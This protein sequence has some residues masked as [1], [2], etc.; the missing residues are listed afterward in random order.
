MESRWTR[1]GTALAA[2]ALVFG[3]FAARSWLAWGHLDADF[4]REMYVPLRLAGGDVIYRDIRY[5]YGPFSSYL[6]ALAYSVWKPHLDV[7]Y[8]SGLLALAGVLATLYAIARQFTTPVA[9]WVATTFSFVELMTFPAHTASFSYVFPYA[10][11]ALHGVLFLSLTLLGCL[12]LVSTDGRRGVF[13]AGIG[14]GLALVTKQEA[15]VT[16]LVLGVMTSLALFVFRGA[17]GRG[18]LRLWLPALGIPALAFGLLALHMPAVDI[19]RKGLFDETYFGWRLSTLVLGFRPGDS[20]GQ[21]AA[22]LGWG[23]L[24]GLRAIVPL[25]LL[26][27]SFGFYP[28]IRFALAQHLR[29]PVVAL[30]IVYGAL[31]AVAF[32]TV[33][34]ELHFRYFAFPGIALLV[35]GASS[36]LL[37]RDAWRRRPAVALRVQVWLASAA[38]CAMLARVPARLGPAN[39]ANFA[40]PLAIVFAVVAATE[41]FG[42]RLPRLGT[43]KRAARASALALFVALGLLVATNRDRSWRMRT[44]RFE[45]PRGTMYF[46][47]QDPAVPG[48][49]EALARIVGETAPGDTVLAIPAET[50]LYFLSGRDTGL[51]ET[52]LVAVLRT[53]AEEVAYMQELLA[54]PPRLVL[55][56]D[57][58]QSEYGRLGFGDDYGR[59]IAG[60]LLRR[61]EPGETVGLVPRIQVWRPRAG[62]ESSG[63]GALGGASTRG[64]G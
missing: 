22:V 5:P 39:Y 41:L 13:V 56:S 32:Y 34:G 6:H 9:A 23:H 12:R 37:L 11:P 46:H 40:L 10:F 47:P 64:D 7:L 44:A 30:V 31:A 1:D 28:R 62:G 26:A 53:E 52:S 25:L 8:A 2:L 18:A 29:R 21:M 61:Y 16:A 48:F 60:W 36:G 54:D 27:G 59:L 51:Y 17:G 19:V 20:V 43:S 33:R 4:G 63:P 45:T 50:S 14:I 35:F 49:S 42:R 15:G 55:L 3:L 24:N 57:R 58:S 38:V